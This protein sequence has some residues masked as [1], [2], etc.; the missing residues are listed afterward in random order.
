MGNVLVLGGTGFLGSWL[1]D[2][3]RSLGLDVFKHGRSNGDFISDFS[4]ADDLQAFLDENEIATVVNCI[5]YTNV[6]DSQAIPLKAYQANCRTLQFIVLA[7]SAARKPPSLVH[8][9]TDHFYDNL[10]PSSEEAK[11]NLKN[12]YAETKFIAEAIALRNSGVV[13]R[14][15]F[16]GFN[17]R[18]PESGFTS[19]LTNAAKRVEKDAMTLFTDVFFSPLTLEN[20]SELLLVIVERPKFGEI[21]NLGSIGGMSKAAFGERFLKHLG[22]FDSRI[23]FSAYK[24]I[25]D[26]TARPLNM[27]MDSKK[28]ERSFGLA[29]PNTA[30]V[31]DA[32]GEQYHSMLS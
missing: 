4:S 28:F 32:V 8:I 26:S 17:P 30:S 20:L 15:N 31:C 16:V 10:V 22:I 13:V 2:R 3:W 14:T 23:R 1:V 27:V 19:W 5:A 12:V 29:L 24:T 11:V 9:S 25:G 18:H 6:G 21:Y 7:L